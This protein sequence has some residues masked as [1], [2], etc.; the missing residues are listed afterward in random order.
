MPDRIPF[1]LLFFLLVIANACDTSTLSG[2]FSDNQPPRTFLTVDRID[3]SEVER[4]ASRVDITWWGDDPDGYVVAYEFCIGERDQQE[5]P[6]YPENGEWERTERTDT[7]ITL[8]IT[9]G[10]DVDDVLFNI[11]AIDNEELRDPEG[12]SVRFPIKNTPPEIRFDPTFTPPDTTYSIMSFGWEASD[13]DG[14]EDLHYLEVTMNMDPD[15]PE[16]S[17]WIR[18]NSDETFLTLD[19]NQDETGGNGNVTAD[20]YLGRAMRDIEETL[21]NVHLN[22]DNTLYIRAYDQS[23]DQ[24]SIATHEWFVKE[25]TSSILLL[26]DDNTVGAQGNISFHAGML[27][28]LGY[29]FDF[30][31]ISEALIPSGNVLPTPFDPTLPL[32]MAQWDH[33]YFI[34]SQ[35]DHNLLY[36]LEF[37]S[38]FLS[39]GGSIFVNIPSRAIPNQNRSAVF[40]FLPFSGFQELPEGESRFT[41]SSGSELEPLTDPLRPLTLANG[42][43]NTYPMIAEGDA[44]LL[45]NADFTLRGDHDISNLISASNLDQSI[46]YF[47]IDM[48]DLT[49]TSPLLETM[50][51]F[52]TEHLGFEMN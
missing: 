31:D 47:G 36:A 2:D 21:E 19:I 30:W 11:R 35:L 42:S 32:V 13:P 49:E 48:R 46:L 3:L 4:L 45:Y 34:S 33:I 22:G 26:N 7:T 14:D 20:V 16:G 25:Q 18:L 50:E 1:F 12:A 52:L 29:D 17:D 41:L 10:Q 24:S 15:D 40:N 28:E 39:Q 51:Y 5:D 37:T 9:E 6:C 38:S 27:N 44:N 43:H 23:L 8:P